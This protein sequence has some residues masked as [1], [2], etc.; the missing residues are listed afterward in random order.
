MTASYERMIASATAPPNTV[1]V[2]SAIAR[3]M[4]CIL[5]VLMITGILSVLPLRD[6]PLTAALVLLLLVLFVASKW[7]FRYGL[8]ASLLAGLAF[9]WLLPPVGRFKSDDPRDLFAVVVFLVVGTVASHLSDRARRE[10]VN[11][12]E[13]R[14]EAVAAQQWFVDLVNSVEGIVWEADANTFAFSF[15]SQQ[16]ERILGYPVER[17]VHDRTFWKD[18]IHPEDR[19]S[20][21][22]FCTRATEERR[23]HEFE[24]RMIAADG[25]IVWLR[26]LV[27]VVVEDGRVSRL[28]GL[29]VD[30]TDRKT[31]EADRERLR[32]LEADLARVN[33][34]TTLGELTASLAH[35]VNQPIAAA[36]TDANT[37]VRWLT[38]AEPDLG[39]ACDAAKRT[40]KDVTRAADIISRMRALFRKSGYEH[41]LVDLND[42]IADI[43]VLVNT[44]AAQHRVS[45][46]TDLASNLPPAMGDRVELQQVVL[47]L[48]MNGIEAMR[49]VG[50]LRDMTVTSHCGDG[51]D[52][53]VDVA[54]TGIGLPPHADEIF[55]A[56]FTTKPEGTGMGL[57]ISRSILESHG[58]RLWAVSNAHGGA[59]FSFTLPAVVAA[60]T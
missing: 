16:A 1:R 36:M 53:V 55:N 35:E 15:V 44:E 34:V 7:G 60:R 57:A 59:T 52:V 10:A 23:N 14:A 33:R 2:R 48:M 12:N 43:L 28:R 45:I 54:D 47:N 29:M 39:E 19:E 20:A 32:Q 18:H 21:V 13:R 22:Q 41:A 31:A 42:L 51:G 4:T 46:H 58:G 11:A 24:Y 50:G 27:T 6:R 30:I 5:A 25:H 3:L 8:V 17:W 37:C 26:D 49:N 40:V 9:S 38:R 56:F